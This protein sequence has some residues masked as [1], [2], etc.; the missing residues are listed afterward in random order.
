MP[1]QLDTPG[2]EIGIGKAAIGEQ[3]DVYPFWQHRFRRPQQRRIVF[4]GDH[5]A[6]VPEDF[7]NHW[8]RASPVD[9]V[10]RDQTSSFPWLVSQV[11]KS[12][13]ACQEA[14]AWRIIGAYNVCTSMASWLSQRMKRRT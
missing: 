4:Q 11:R 2:H 3:H 14:K 8:H 5:A 9:D 1:T 10:K 7:P 12:R 6:T 13:G